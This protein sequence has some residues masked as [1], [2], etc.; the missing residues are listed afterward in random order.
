[1]DSYIGLS[2]PEGN[3]LTVDTMMGPCPVGFLGEEDLSAFMKK[4]EYKKVKAMHPHICI[5]YFIVTPGVYPH[6]RFK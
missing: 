5:C 6:L 2:T 4:D 1:M 3:L